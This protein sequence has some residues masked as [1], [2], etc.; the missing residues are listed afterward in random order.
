M[1]AAGRGRAAAALAGLSLLWALGSLRGDLWPGLLREAEALP[2]LE[3]QAL[4][5]A[6]LAAG[7]AALVALAGRARWPQGRQARD[8]VFAGLGLLAVPALL[9]DAAGTWV[10]GLTRVALFSLTPVLAVVLEPYLGGEDAAQTHGA[11]LPALVAVAGVLCVFPVELPGGP[12][13][14]LAWAAVVLAALCAAAAN[15]RAVRAAREA[16]EWRAAPMAALAAA[17]AAVVLGAASACTVRV[18]VPPG[19]ATEAA[20]LALVDLPALLLLFWL[21]KRMTAARMTL[22]FVLAPLLASLASVAL[23]RPAVSLRAAAGLALMTAGAG[24]MLVRRDV[25]DEDGTPLRLD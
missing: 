16:A 12:Q 21:M 25:A 11:L 24:W 7:A 1:A 22:R 23:L 19:M 5:W 2:L 8:A 13:A 3:R 20:W 9:V 18:V 17:T 10:D 15:C 6:G 14:A 4:E